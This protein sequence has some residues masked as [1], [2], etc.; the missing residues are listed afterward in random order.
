MIRAAGVVIANA[1][2]IRAIYSTGISFFNSPDQDF[3]VSFDECNHHFMEGVVQ[4]AAA[5]GDAM[6]TLINK[7]L[8]DK[9][10]GWSD[11]SGHPAYFH[12]TAKV[13]VIVLCDR[14]SWLERRLSGGSL[15]DRIERA[16]RGA[17]R[18]TRDLS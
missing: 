14:A 16:V 18:R 8:I 15:F 2:E 4:Y 11:A 9:Y 12:F 7:D 17:D 13:P 3:V 10:V 5:V 6:P 1:K